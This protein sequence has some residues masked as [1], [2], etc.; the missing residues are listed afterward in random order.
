MTLTVR[1]LGRIDYAEALALQ[2]EL[3]S[4]RIADRVPDQ[5]LLLEH[6]PVY[7]LGRGADAADLR[8]A[9]VQFGVPAFRVSRGG[10]V[11]FHG[12]GQLVA[13]PIIKLTGVRRDVRWYLQRLEDVVIRSCA[14]LGVVA[15]R[16]SSGTGVW[17]GDAKVASIGVGLRRWV[18]LHGLAVNVSTDLSYFR[19]IVPCRLPGLR[20]TSLA[21]LLPSAPTVEQVATVVAR[22]FSDLF[23][24][25]AMEEVAA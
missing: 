11:T 9:E 3:V 1:Q 22:E 19:A 14:A 16:H 25:S 8:G 24:A 21:E 4:E 6:N 23:V 2:E 10:G 15:H 20:V 7:T 12:A 13:Y 18:T 17:V 5:L